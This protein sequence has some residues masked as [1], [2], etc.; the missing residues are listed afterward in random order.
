MIT[1][2]FISANESRAAACKFERNR[3]QENIRE[4]VASGEAGARGS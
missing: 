3:K 4:N 1:V 2:N